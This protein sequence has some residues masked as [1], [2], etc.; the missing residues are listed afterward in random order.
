MSRLI[1]IFCGLYP[2]VIQSLNYCQYSDANILA[3]WETMK[4]SSV[5]YIIKRKKPFF[6]MIYT[7]HVY[8][9]SAPSPALCCIEVLLKPL[10]EGNN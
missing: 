4:F 3:I 5:G 8:F 1:Q 7:T 10:Q 9:Q 2:S 6:R